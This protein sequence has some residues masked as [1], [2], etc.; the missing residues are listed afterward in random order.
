MIEKIG[1]EWKRTVQMIHDLK[2]KIREE[3][4]REENGENKKF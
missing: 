2:N 4:I 1:E 3:I